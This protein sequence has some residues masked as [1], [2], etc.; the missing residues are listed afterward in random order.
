MDSI[1]YRVSN[2]DEYVTGKA[3]SV[4]AAKKAIKKTIP[5]LMDPTGAAGYITLD[6]GNE[7]KIWKSRFL[8]WQ[9]KEGTRTVEF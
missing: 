1:R 9:E 4:R 6:G 3:I 7:I 5:C 8:G 2:G